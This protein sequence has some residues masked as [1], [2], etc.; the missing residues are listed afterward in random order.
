PAG[1]IDSVGDLD[2]GLA[3]ID[4]AEVNDGVHFDGDVVARDHILL[5]HAEHDDPQVHLAHALH[6]RIDEHQARSLDAPEASQREHHG[7]LVLVQ[8]VDGAEEQ[9]DDEYED[10]D[11]ERHAKLRDGS[12]LT[13]AR[14]T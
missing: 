7:A 3:G 1:G 14:R 8:H 10:S 6:D 2:D 4:D 5:R 9:H 13:A 11:H 12:A